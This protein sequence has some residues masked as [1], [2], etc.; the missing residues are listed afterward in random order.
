MAAPRIALPSEG[1]VWQLYLAD[2][3]LI[4]ALGKPGINAPH[5]IYATR[6][7]D[8]NRGVALALVSSG[9]Y[10]SGAVWPLVFERVIPKI[11]RRQTIL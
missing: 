5:L 3:L 10:L 7:F 9:H 11:G 1:A 2:G 8:K 4:V 6:W